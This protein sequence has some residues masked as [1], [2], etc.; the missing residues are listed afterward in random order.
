[1]SPDAQEIYATERQAALPPSSRRRFLRSLGGGVL[2]ATTITAFGDRAQAAA[3][4]GP[5]PL[6]DS[7]EI[8][9]GNSLQEQTP[10]PFIRCPLFFDNGHYGHFANAFHTLDLS[11]LQ[12]TGRVKGTITFHED[13]IEPDFSSSVAAAIAQGSDGAF[14][15]LVGGEGRVARGAGYF[16]GVDQ[17]IVRCKYKVAGSRPLLISCI[18]CV[19]ILVR[20]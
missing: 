2:G 3:T 10:S 18:L 14:Y 11:E 19:V 4:S 6:W 5:E 9:I 8:L 1:M 20:K 17:A 7:A 16:S 12:T 15:L 13:T